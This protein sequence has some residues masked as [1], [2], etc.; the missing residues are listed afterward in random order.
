MRI[1]FSKS[2]ELNK[3]ALPSFQAEVATRTASPSVSEESS[4]ASLTSPVG[5]EEAG[6]QAEV[7]SDKRQ[8]NRHDPAVQEVLLALET[9]RRDAASP[10]TLPI[11]PHDHRL[12]SDYRGV[13]LA[14]LKAVKIFYARHGALDL[15]MGDVCKGTGKHVSKRSFFRVPHRCINVCMLTL[16]T[17][18]S[19]AESVVH[20]A[21]RDGLHLARAQVARAR[22]F[23][24]YSWTG[25]A[26]A[27]M[28]EAI[29]DVVRPLEAKSGRRYVWVDMFCASQNLLAG[30]YRSP[31]VSKE[32]DPAGYLARKEDTD[33]I[34]DDALEAVS[35]VYFYCSPLVGEWVAP[36][37]PFLSPLR[38]AKGPPAQPWV[39]RGAAA[40][41]RAW[42]LFELSTALW[43]GCE[44][45]VALSRADREAFEELL[46]TDFDEIASI[47][48]LIDA[49]DAQISKVEDRGYILSR[50]ES[51]APGAADAE[52]EGLSLVTARVSEALRGWLVASAREVL[53]SVVPAEPSVGCW[54]TS[55]RR[56]QNDR[57]FWRSILLN[58]VG[59]L[60]QSAG[61]LDAAE[62][63]YRESLG[64]EDLRI[65]SAGSLGMLLLTKGD[66]DGACPLL[67]EA[68]DMDRELFGWHP[69]TILAT[70]NLSQTLAA[71]GDLTGAEALLREALEGGRLT[72][73]DRD[74]MMLS[75]ICNLG[76]T[77]SKRGKLDDA[78]P[79]LREALEGQR[80]TLGS[81][82]RDTLISIN[83]LGM[84]LQGKGDR[85]GAEALLR[86][87]FEGFCETHG[88]QHPD[89][90]DV[91]QFLGMLLLTKGDL[92]DAE[93]M[94]HVVLEVNRESFGERN[95]RTLQTIFLF[96][97]L[98]HEKGDLDGAEALLREALEG[99]EAVFGDQHPNTLVAIGNLGFL[100]KDKGDLDGAEPMCRKALE[101]C[102]ELFGDNHRQTI[103][104]AGHYADLLR[105]TGD[106][107]EARRII[108]DA[109]EAARDK[110]EMDAPDVQI[111]NLEAQAARIMIACGEAGT[112]ALREVVARMVAALGAGHP[113]TRKYS[114]LI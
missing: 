17:G 16:S 55:C 40:I 73:D 12:P 56:H 81:R 94:L 111:L 35:E 51:L 39:R 28:L 108:G 36:P 54:A 67:R 88:R 48:A 112:N 45:H 47:V 97:K 91:S 14:F 30:V 85:D 19:L 106:V 60:L 24:S 7:P 71:K 34:F 98:L 4:E 82:Q 46:T 78:E 23:F 37:H 18:L 38:E 10:A 50:I 52:A 86:E 26:L 2:R 20:V 49:R 102:R 79:L 105:E 110:L 104:C 72:L 103:V 11:T 95:P 65:I 59:V 76:A 61:D 43:E 113:R 89:T 77:L 109:L 99:H 96:G 87:A 80:E 70:C 44:L 69:R 33:R 32:S 6:Q 100:M 75:L 27:D 29:E 74:R 42:C 101:G 57:C 63:L 93:S 3:A 107:N 62:A 68:V 58:Q 90:L 22:G 92:E 1:W 84:L 53:A 64:N 13:S 15:S 21:E 9:L 25:T 8:N 66:L 5:V 31:A 83:H 41:T 114:K